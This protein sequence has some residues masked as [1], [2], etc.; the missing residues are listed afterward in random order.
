MS[1]EVESEAMSYAKPGAMRSVKV[2]LK[3]LL[4]P[5]IFFTR[6]RYRCV[7]CGYFGPFAH[8][9]TAKYL[10]SRLEREVPELQRHGEAPFSMANTQRN[11]SSKCMVAAVSTALCARTLSRRTIAV[12]VSKGMLA[13]ISFAAM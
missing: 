10:R 2:A 12:A 1:P 9:R 11:Y 6:Q 4:F 5:L 13:L 7:I 8:K 3:R